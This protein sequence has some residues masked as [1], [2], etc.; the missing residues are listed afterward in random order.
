MSRLL[1]FMLTLGIVWILGRKYLTTLR[2]KK[3]QSVSSTTAIQPIETMVQCAFC[4][5]YILKR[6]AITVDQKVFCCEAHRQA[7]REQ[8]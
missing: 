3:N 4:G 8:Q 1:I 2:Q 6:E 7:S 5:V